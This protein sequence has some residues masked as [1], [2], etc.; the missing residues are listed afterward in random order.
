MSNFCIEI[1]KIFKS[2]IEKMIS[3][4]LGSYYIFTI[5]INIASFKCFW[6]DYCIMFYTGFIMFLIILNS[7]NINLF[8]NNFKD[9]FGFIDSCCGKGFFFLFISVIF[10]NFNIKNLNYSSKILGLGGIILILLEICCFFDR[11]NDKNNNEIV[12]IKNNE[13]NKI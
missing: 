4:L 10:Y 8:F 2:I 5:I 9:L 11:K 7:I 1:I 6:S 3:I 12:N 13:E